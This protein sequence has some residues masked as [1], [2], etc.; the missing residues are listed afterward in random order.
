MFHIFIDTCLWL[1]IAKDFKKQAMLGVLE[2]FVRQK[3]ISIIQP[4]VDRVHFVNANA[5]D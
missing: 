4:R 2:E 5:Y 1:D 3:R